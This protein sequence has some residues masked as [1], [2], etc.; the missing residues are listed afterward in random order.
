MEPSERLHRICERL[1][2]EGNTVKMGDDWVRWDLELFGGM[3]GSAR[4]LMAVED[5]GAGAQY[6]RT[7]ITPRC[8]S[9]AAI[10]L[11]LFGTLAPLALFSGAYSVAGTFGFF[12]TLLLVRTV[13]QEG[14]A[15][16]ALMRVIP[17][18]PPPSPQPVAGKPA[19][20]RG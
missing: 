14:Q 11:L 13:Q 6:V 1:R 15:T 19:D 8:R 10:V 18:A 20:V 12:W 3:F 2:K 17:T 4:L 5:H 9:G 7:R 16:A